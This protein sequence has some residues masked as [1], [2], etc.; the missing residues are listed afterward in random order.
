MLGCSDERELYCDKPF[1]VS[2]WDCLNFALY[3]PHI[4]YCMLSTDVMSFYMR[5]LSV[6]QRS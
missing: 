5:E 6:A 2:K 3:A 1:A 4:K